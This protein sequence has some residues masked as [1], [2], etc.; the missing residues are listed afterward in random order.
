MGAGGLA[1][2]V[3][4]SR[5]ISPPAPCFLEREKWGRRRG[6]IFLSVFHFCESFLGTLFLGHRWYR[7][8]F[9][10]SIH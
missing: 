9:A 8:V 6:F 7:G 3:L 2:R 10:E 5:F 4:S 1:R